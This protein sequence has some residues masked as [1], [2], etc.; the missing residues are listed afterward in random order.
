MKKEF[1]LG[2]SNEVIK[3]GRVYDLHNLYDFVGIMLTRKS[4]QLRVLFKPS[5]AFNG[6]EVPISFVFDDID[7]LEFSLDFSSPA[8]HNLDEMGYK[9]PNDYDDD[10]LLDELQSTLDDHFF[11]RLESNDFIRVHCQHAD[12]IEYVKFASV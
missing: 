9:N 7:Y 1:L 2:Q 12:I 4:R 5:S 3:A 11:I 8:I 6:N 10:W